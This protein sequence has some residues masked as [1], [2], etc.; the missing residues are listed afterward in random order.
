MTEIAVWVI[1]SDA[2]PM[3]QMV[4]SDDGYDPDLQRVV[5][6]TGPDGSPASVRQLRPGSPYIDLSSVS[7]GSY[8]NVAY[9]SG[10]KAIPPEMRDAVAALS[11]YILSP[12]SAPD[13]AISTSTDAGVVR[14]VVAGLD[15][16][17]TSLPEVNAVIQ[18]YGLADPKVG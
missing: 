7:P 3:A 14:F 5:R 10:L 8:V 4:M 9:V 18:R 16:A 6:A 12:R 13:N 15:G 11:A 1:L 2:F 17:A